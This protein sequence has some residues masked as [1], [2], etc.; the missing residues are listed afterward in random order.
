M[1]IFMYFPTSFLFIF[2]LF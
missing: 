1:I 2:W